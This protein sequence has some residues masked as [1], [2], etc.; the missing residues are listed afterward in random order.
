[1]PID[2]SISP[3]SFTYVS[4][5]DVLEGRVPRAVLAGKTV[6]V[7]ATAVELND[8]LPVPVYGSLPGIVVQ[9]LA[10]ET[11]NAGAPR[12][13]PTWASLALLALLDGCCAARCCIGAR[14][15]RNLAVLALALVGASPAL[16]L[17]RVLLRTGC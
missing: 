11:V 15:R 4:Y 7:G 16:S 12:E 5:V 17:Y 13:P 2:F 14:W 9:A 6:F 1:M 10:A 3:A 8:M